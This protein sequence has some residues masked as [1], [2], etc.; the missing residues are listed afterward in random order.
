MRVTKR[1]GTFAPVD[2]NKIT[3]RIQRECEDAKLTEPDPVEL[4]TV[5]VR[6]LYD[7]VHTYELDELAAETAAA[8]AWTHPQWGKLAARLV[9]SNLHKQTGNDKHTFSGVVAVLAKQGALGAEF[10]DLV[11]SLA[12]ELDSLINYTRDYDFTYFGARTLL[13][14]KYL[15]PGERPQDI[16]MREAVQIH[17]RA[18]R[19]A[20]VAPPLDARAKYDR[21]LVNVRD[22]YTLLSKQLYTHGSPTLFNAG[23]QRPQLSSCFLLTIVDDSIEGI[24]ETLARVAAISKHGGG[25]GVS[26]SNIR[27]AGAPI[28]KTNGTSQGIRPM[29]Q[30]FNATSRYVD[31]GGGKRKGSFAIYLEPWHLDVETFLEMRKPSTPRDKAAHD[32][33]YALWIPDLF[34]KRVENDL[35]WTLLCPVDA[36]DLVDLHSKPFETAYEAYEQRVDAKL[37]RGRK[38]RARDLWTQI[39][40][41]QIEAGTPYMMFKDAANAKSNQKNLGTIRASNLCTEIV[42]Y[43]S[44]DQV[45]VCNLASVAL[46]KFVRNGTFDFDALARTV[47]LVV[48]NLDNVIDENYYPRPEAANS[49]QLHRPVGLGVQGLADV[50]VLLGLPYESNQAHLL[51]QDIFETLYYAALD[52]SNQLAIERGPYSSF[53]GSPLSKGHFQFDLWI[54]RGD[55]K[56]NVVDSFRAKRTGSGPDWAGLRRRI[57]QHGV[58]NS[59]LISPMPTAS[60]A[61]ILGNTESFEPLTSNA[62]V[63]RVLSGEY[64]VCNEYLQQTLIGAGLWTDAVRNNILANGGSVQQLRP[65][66]GDQVADIFK[67]VWEIKQ[68]SIV[69]A[70]ANRGLFVD[71]SQSLNLHLQDP[72]HSRLTSY[73]FYAWKLGLKT[74]MYYFRTRPAVDPIKF[75]LDTDAVAKAER[76]STAKRAS[77]LVSQAIRDGPD[78]CRKNDPDC[79]ACSG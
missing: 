38:I 75:T 69:Q 79:E 58:R 78:F 55:A 15:L 7:K 1:D 50:F 61:Q 32:L 10:A 45:A 54:H 40:D 74:G 37:I 67:T 39:I 44:N 49:N 72:T 62:Y 18:L 33:F 48:Q 46:P 9:V 4:A 63:R 41:S 26:I 6:G 12:D 31:Q 47:A 3:Q 17:S 20:L 8:R 53:E 13:R 42:Q 51:N 11:D 28:R 64:P 65:L 77:D 68:R 36:P 29:L 2:L 43:T 70:A 30:V 19:D 34:M 60:T 24:Y 71:Q 21:A 56:P 66:V 23:T 73:H 5:V 57:Q 22:T 14:G 16:F 76:D 52:T 59:L 25:I 35:E 27:A